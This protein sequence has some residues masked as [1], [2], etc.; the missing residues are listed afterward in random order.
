MY[1]FYIHREST[2]LPKID[3]TEIIDKKFLWWKWQ[4]HDTGWV[5]LK[6]RVHKKVINPRGFIIIEG[7][8]DE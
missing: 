3:P 4:S 8:D 7:D 5:L 1:D 6:K 2:N